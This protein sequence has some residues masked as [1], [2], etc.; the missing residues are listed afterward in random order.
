[1]PIYEFKCPKCKKSEET[2]FT[3]SE[4][5]ELYDEDDIGRCLC[6]QKIYKKDQ[7]INFAGGINMNNSIKAKA[8]RKYSNK[9]GGP[10]GIVGGQSTGKATAKQGGKV[11]G[12]T[13]LL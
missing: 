13:G 2:I 12:R 8:Y 1:M 5:R 4:Y 6:G 11:V 9:Q 10:Q 7:V 3:F